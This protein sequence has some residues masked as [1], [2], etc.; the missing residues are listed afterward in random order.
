MASTSSSRPGASGYARVRVEVDARVHRGLRQGGARRSRGARGPSP[1]PR[2][3][4][5]APRSPPRCARCASRRW[6]HHDPS[7]PIAPGQRERGLHVERDAGL[8][9]RGLEGPVLVAGSA[10]CAWAAASRR[11]SSHAAKARSS[12]GTRR[13]SMTTPRRLGARGRRRCR[14]TPPTA[15]TRVMRPRTAV[16]AERRTGRVD[17]VAEGYAHRNFRILRQ[18]AAPRPPLA[19]PSSSV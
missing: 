12:S 1:R 3:T 11:E 10:R 16:K 13:S 7:C 17:M 4:R 6:C 9:E 5:P 18:G 2:A 8:L 14:A 19:A 15:A